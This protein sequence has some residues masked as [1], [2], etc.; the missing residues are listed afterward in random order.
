MTLIE[1]QPVAVGFGVTANHVAIQV[2]T[3][4]IKPKEFNLNARFYNVIPATDD[5]P[6][7][8]E[9]VANVPFS[10][11]LEVYD[12]WDNDLYLENESLKKLNLTRA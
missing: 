9:E 4:D 11:P 2:L 8:K 12:N 10:L 1:I 3:L 5:K 6:E 7:Q